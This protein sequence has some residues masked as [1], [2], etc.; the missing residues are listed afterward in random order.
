MVR[1]ILKNRN[2]TNKVISCTNLTNYTVRNFLSSKKKR[3][4]GNKSKKN[5]INTMIS[6]NSNFI[7][8]KMTKKI[9]NL[10]NS[11]IKIGSIIILLSTKYQGKKVILL[12]IT[13][14]GLYVISGLYK[15]NGIPIRRVNPKY[16]FPTGV[17]IDI[18]DI[19]TKIF[20]DEYFDALKK[21]KEYQNNN[22][23]NRIKMSH[24][25]RQSYIDRF[26]QKKIDKDIFLAPYLK[27]N[28]IH[29]SL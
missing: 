23:T 21:Y 8:R 12:R 3:L 4:L 17:Y 11:N 22:F 16:I 20:S 18:S 9:K 1:P 14:S 28:Y 13:K 7:F 29:T 10:E 6:I 15:L 27:S 26:L 19:N 2:W 24:N 25:L 5:N